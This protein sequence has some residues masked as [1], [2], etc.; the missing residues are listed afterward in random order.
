MYA[1]ADDSE[2]GASIQSRMFLPPLL[3]KD[4]PI[5][6]LT[7]LVQTEPEFK[8]IS[9]TFMLRQRIK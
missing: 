7:D 1:D 5:F 8:P 3:N 2:G 6:N 9:Y 4:T